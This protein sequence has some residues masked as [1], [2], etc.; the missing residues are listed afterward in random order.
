MVGLDFCSVGF[1][2]GPFLGFG[3]LPREDEVGLELLGECLL[4]V[5]EVPALV[6]VAIC[7]L[8][9]TVVVSS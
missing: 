4:G 2:A 1:S 8:R 7:S 3:F 9:N 6:L 5:L